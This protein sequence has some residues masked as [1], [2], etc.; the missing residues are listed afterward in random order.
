MTRIVIDDKNL[1]YAEDC[2]WLDILKHGESRLS[3]SLSLRQFDEGERL[4]C[5]IYREP[6]MKG[7][8]PIHKASIPVEAFE[9]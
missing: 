6:R 5:E 1:G 9:S 2:I 7:D 8:K 3:A 4:V